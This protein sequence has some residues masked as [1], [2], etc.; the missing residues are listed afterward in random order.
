M[1]QRP[2]DK[3][4]YPSPSAIS[5]FLT[6]TIPTEQTLDCAKLA[7]SKSMATKLSIS[8]PSIFFYPKSAK[9]IQ[10]GEW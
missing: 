6:M 3:G 2:A 10:F 7:V 8:S 5:P 9:I 4:G 1:L